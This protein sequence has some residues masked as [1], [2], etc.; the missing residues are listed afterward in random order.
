VTR[1]WRADYDQ[2]KRDIRIM[3][4]SLV[5]LTIPLGMLVL[6]GSTRTAKADEVVKDE[7]VTTG[8]NRAL[9]HSGIWILGLSYVPAVIVAAESS[10]VGDRRLYIPV[11]G[12][13]MDLASRSNCPA[14]VACGNE[15][16][17]KVLI[18][19]DGIFQGIGALNIVGAFLFPETRTVSVSSTEPTVTRNSALTLHVL[20][21]QVG[22]SAYGLAAVG[23]F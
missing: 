10:R 9:L 2:K 13:W 16:T 17:N 21:A 6:A 23:T 8:P 5:I 20:P 22:A 3:K 14:N 15:T 19:V 1:L 7:S 12:P 4:R 18:V 11:A